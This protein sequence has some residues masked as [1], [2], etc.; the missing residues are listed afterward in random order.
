[1]KKHPFITFFLFFSSA[2]SFAQMTILLDSSSVKIE[3]II[4][5]NECS[6]PWDVQ[7]G[8]DNRLWY[9]DIDAIKVWNPTDNTIKTIIKKFTGNFMGLALHPNFPIVPEVYATWDTSAYYSYGDQIKVLKYTYSISGDSLTGETQLLEYWHPGEHSGGRIIVSSDLKLM[10]TTSEYFCSSDTASSYYP[11]KI[12]RMNLDGS[13][14]NDNPLAGNYMYTYGH[15]NAQGIVEV[16]NKTY[17]SEFGYINDELNLLNPNHYYGWGRFDGNTEYPIADTLPNCLLANYIPPIDVGQNPPSGIDYYNKDSIPEF[18]NCILESV[19]SFGGVT[20]GL[21]AFRLNSA[22]DSVIHKQHYFI[23]SGM[24]RIRDVTCDNQGRI[25]VISNDRQDARIRMIYKEP[26][27]L[28]MT[29]FTKETKIIVFPNPTTDVLLFSNPENRIEKASIMD[30][31][32]RILFSKQI[33]TMAYFGTI[34]TKQLSSGTYF[35]CLNDKNGL[36][37]SVQKIIRE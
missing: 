25:Y 20:G 29:S 32:G 27:P 13:I 4:D 12:L 6:G 2:S 3:T 14:P 26:A 19:L 7:W 30:V 17:I 36:L 37:I 15:R 1:M 5:S 16:N 8:P 21:I 35:L 22:G 24:K 28:G 11:G 33:D 18:N 23:G 34:E 9:T 10:F 31:Q